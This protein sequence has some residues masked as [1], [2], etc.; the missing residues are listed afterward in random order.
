MKSNDLKVIKDCPTS[1]WAKE[2]LEPAMRREL[3]R[4]TKYIKPVQK[5]RKD[6]ERTTEAAAE[7]QVLMRML[8][9]SQEEIQQNH[10]SARDAITP[11]CA[12]LL[13]CGHQATPEDL[14]DQNWTTRVISSS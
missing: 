9:S 11:S 2:A 10:V 7:N 4:K 1:S 12:V 8:S 5:A 3:V 13:A 14:E 6:E